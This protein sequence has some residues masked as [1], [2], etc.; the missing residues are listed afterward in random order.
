MS[1]DVL[2]VGSGL[3]GVTLARTLTD[4]GKKV[5]V[6]EKNNYIGGACYDVLYDQLPVSKFG[7]HIFHTNIEKV[8]EFINRFS[9]FHFYEHVVTAKNNN[10]Y[11]PIPV[12][13]LT[14]NRLYGINS[15][16]EAKKYFQSLPY[17]GESNFEERA[18]SA[19]GED[20]YYKFFYYYTKK[21]W[22]LDPKEL[23]AFVFNRIPVRYNLDSRY[24][25][26][27]YQ[28]I[29]DAGYTQLITNML[30][31]IDVQLET[32]F[33]ENMTSYD[34]LIYTGC[35]DEFFDYRFGKLG[36][37]SVKH[38]YEFKDEDELGSASVNFTGPEE[39]YTRIVGYNYF[40]PQIKNNKWIEVKE[41]ATDE[42]T[43]LYPIPT[44]SNKELYKKYKDIQTNVIF[45]GRLGRYVYVNMD[46]CVNSALELG[47]KL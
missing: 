30:K 29:P 33:S 42:G 37:R 14:L 24:F 12:N 32:S 39:T 15:V 27:K 38:E 41:W 20:L 35:I 11:F 31:G 43:P 21:Q 25:T 17:V 19:L 9:T 46:Q 16:L 8:W 47:E 2:I 18:I 40:Y 3:S 44:Q 5:L 10:E 34:T 7:A 1:Y 23:P 4:R 45:L 22:G 28:A 6:I 36:Y 26:D 13:L